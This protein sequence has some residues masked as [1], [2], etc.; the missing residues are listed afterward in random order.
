MEKA[1]LLSEIAEIDAKLAEGDMALQSAYNALKQEK[2]ARIAEIDGV[3]E[4]VKKGRAKKAAV[5]EEAEVV[6]EEA[7]LVDG[8]VNQD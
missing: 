5:E 6:T 2:L 1:K 4:P 7:E 8:E 3:N